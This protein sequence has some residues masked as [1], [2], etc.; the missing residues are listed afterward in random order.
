VQLD[1]KQD[2]KDP[3]PPAIG[4][5]V[6]LGGEKSSRDPKHAYLKRNDGAWIHF[7]ITV[8]WDGDSKVDLDS[9]DFEIVFP[10]GHQPPWCR[11]DLNPPGHDNEAEGLRS[12][13]HPGNDDLIMPAP[14]M[15]PE[16]I[17][18]LFIDGLRPRDP[19]KPRR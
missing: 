6:I 17:L 3:D 16:E 11:I 8:I 12:H 4:P 13:L 9:Y 15:T 7:K 2:K 5:H 19:A 1:P 10:P 18:K 14:V